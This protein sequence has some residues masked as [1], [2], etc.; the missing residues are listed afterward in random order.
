MKGQISNYMA[1]IAFLFAFGIST[2]I[3]LLILTNFITTIDATGLYVGQAKVAGTAFLNTLAVFDYIIM[4]VMIGLFIGV[5]LTT[6]RLKTNIAFFIA[7]FI[8]AAFLGFFG[9]I[10]NY[11]FLQFWSQ[12]VFSSILVYLPKTLVLLTNL[13]WIGLVFLVL[14]SIGL[15]AKRDKTEEGLVDL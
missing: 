5:L 8:M 1:G 4:F 11:V 13:H 14:G 2:M 3:A 15:Y 12:D 9:Y 6:Y 10:M 7:S